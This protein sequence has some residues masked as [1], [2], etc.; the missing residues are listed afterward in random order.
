MADAAVTPGDPLALPIAPT[1][2]LTRAAYRAARPSLEKIL[3]I[4]RLRNLYLEVK[5]LPGKTFEGRVLRALNVRVRIDSADGAVPAAGPVIVAANHP[6]G[7]LDGLV[8]AE[9]LREF[10]ADVRILTNGLLARIPETAASCLFVNPFGGREATLHNRAALRQAHEWLR[11]GGALILFPAGEV[12][13]RRTDTGRSADSPWHPAVGRLASSTGAE[14]VPAFL[15]GRNS[16]LFYAAGRLHPLLRTASL[17]RELLNKRGTTCTVRLGAPVRA[18]RS[19]STPEALTDLCRRAADE[20]AH[21][22]QAMAEEVRPEMDRSVLAGDIAALPDSAKLLT[23]GAYDV[24]CAPATSI[25]N[26]LQEIGRLRELTFRAVGEGTGRSVDLDRFDDHYQHLFLWHR[27]RRE[28]V[29][30]YRIGAADRILAIF[31]VDGLY[32]RTLFRYDERMLQRLGPALELGRSFVRAEYQR[33]YNALLLLWKGIG[34]FVARAPEYRVLFGPV[35]ISSRY[36]DRSQQLLRAFL[37]QEHADARLAELVEPMNPPAPLAPPPQ[38]AVAPV[39]LD[40]LDALVARIEGTQGIPVLLRQY[41]RLNATLLGFNVDPAFGDALDALM[42]VDLV[43][44]S[45]ATLSRY[46][47]ADATAF[48]EY[49][50]RLAA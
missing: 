38:D 3:G 46:L 14:V 10:R 50:R 27:E 22:R 9:A 37:A 16:A 18:S 36:H 17:G 4:D 40:S 6:T 30:G 11:S 12:A 8:L 2:R 7:V 45:P 48:L 42:M 44:V 31:G 47:G 39:D 34:R 23:S 5:A 25:P 49:H 29:G 21:D 32:T 35:S 20:L 13:W 15:D 19:D 24:Y 41:L 1:T 33:S 28:V 26:V 43:R